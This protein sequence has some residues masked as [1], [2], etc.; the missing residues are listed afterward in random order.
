MRTRWTVGALALLFFLAASV[1][2]ADQ[3]ARI[4]G[5]IGRLQG[6][7]FNDI[8]AAQDELVEIGLP[9][10]PALRQALSN[11]EPGIRKGA[12]QVLGEL[13]VIEAID[14]I[15]A[16]VK[17]DVY[18]VARGAIYSLR[19]MESPS[20]NPYFV[21]ALGHFN[22]K[23]KETA[24]Y[25]VKDLKLTESKP[26]LADRMFRDLDPYIRWQA[27]T[28]LRE[29][30]EGAEIAAIREAL[31][32]PKRS[33]T[34]L[35]NATELAGNLRLKEAVPELLP[36]LKNSEAKVRWG[37]IRALGRIG[38]ETTREPIERMLKDRDSDVRLMA[39]GALGMLADPASVAPLSGMLSGQPTN[40]RKNALRS[41]ER[42]G[43]TQA[44][45]AVRNGLSDRD[46]LVRAQAAEILGAIG[47]PADGTVLA[48]ASRDKFAIV[49]VAALHA[50]GQLRAGEGKAAAE[51][52]LQDKNFWVSQEARRTLEL[53]GTEPAVPGKEQ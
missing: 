47:S 26:K 14:E 41:L 53:L 19:E 25:A 5:L 3:D 9:A 34:Q 12:A 48:E 39:V 11:S 7:N 52:A 28:V 1:V 29:L 27:M 13:K 18:W 42:I 51:A 50:L 45:A 33:A 23:V 36:L 15:G 10:V 44:A 21:Q 49:R 31:A 35:R 24:L 20:A 43:G 17:D 4:A 8:R 32:D 2:Q 38:E 16:L 22:A 46:K 40:V 6:F 37:A 30:E